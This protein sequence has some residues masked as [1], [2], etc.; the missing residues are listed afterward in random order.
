[1]YSKTLN[2]ALEIDVFDNKD[3]PHIT[4][5]LICILDDTGEVLQDAKE[6]IENEADSRTL[7]LIATVKLQLTVASAIANNILR[8]FTPGEN[9]EEF[10]AKLHEKNAKAGGAE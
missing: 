8:A 6:R 2:D 5:D 9:V 1:M 3:L 10:L 4:E 7:A